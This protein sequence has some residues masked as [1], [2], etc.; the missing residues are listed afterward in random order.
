MVKHLKVFANRHLPNTLGVDGK[1]T[2]IQIILTEYERII[3][4]L[5]TTLS[6]CNTY[7][8]EIAQCYLRKISFIL[9]L[10]VLAEKLIFH[11]VL[12]YR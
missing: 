8:L 11:S 3:S 12:R 2:L 10:N 6:L 7:N 1:T 4:T 9:K 5:L